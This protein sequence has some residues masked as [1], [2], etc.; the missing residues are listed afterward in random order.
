MKKIYWHAHNIPRYLM[1][2]MCVA[3]LVGLFCAE[4]FKQFVPLPNYA[5]KLEAAQVASQAFAVI[6][7]ARISKGIKIDRKYD[8]QM[9]GLIGRRNTETTT[10][11]GVVL[12][13][14]TSVNPNIA[15]IIVSWM[16]DAKLKKGD[17]VAIGMTGS[18]PA[19]DAS[20]LSAV[21]VLG[22]KPVLIVSAAASQW[23][24]NI[25]GF[26]WLDMEHVLNLNGVIPYKP[27]AASLGGVRDEAGAMSEEGRAIL[28]ATIDKYKIPFIKPEGTISSIDERMGIYERAAGNQP[29]KL[30]INVGGGMASIGLHKPADAASKQIPKSVKELK[31]HRLTAGL[32]TS[33]PISLA[34]T[35]SIAVRFLKQGVPVINLRNV[36]TIARD[37]NLPLGP[38]VAPVIGQGFIYFRDEYSR[39]LATVVL[40]LLI[41]LLIGIS[42]VSKKY[43]IRYRQN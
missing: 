24:A 2:L 20:V 7:R 19:V 5:K 23:G 9:S 27:V 41:L 15:A 38:R 40:G 13:K 11:K 3:A 25:P 36:D 34:N 18:F 37:Y 28:K 31:R 16:L 12:A 29:I 1:I 4:H 39:L 43:I 22:L 32:N 6:K 33:L 10:D 42:I 8:P 30:Y 17:V 21:K 14:Q 35:D 26:L